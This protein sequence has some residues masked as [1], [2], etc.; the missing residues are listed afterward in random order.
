MY[1]LILWG[2]K[3]VTQVSVQRCLFTA[4]HNIWIKGVFKK[5]IFS[6]NNLFWIWK[7]VT[8]LLVSVS[9]QIFSE[10]WVR[11]KQNLHDIW[12]CLISCK[13]HIATE[14]DSLYRFKRASMS[15]VIVLTNCS[16]VRIFLKNFTKTSINTQ[17]SKKIQGVCISFLWTSALV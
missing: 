11:I 1:L 15:R 3:L 10:L 2:L 14:I 8:N 12:C 17:L 16:Y 9:S 6:L 4:F 7:T 5:W 13:G